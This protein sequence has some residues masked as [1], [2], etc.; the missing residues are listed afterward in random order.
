VLNPNTTIEFKNLYNQIGDHET[1][2]RQGQNLVQ[3]PNDELQNYGYRYNERRIYSG[4]L[5]GTHTFGDRRNTLSWLVGSNYLLRN[6]P[7]FRRFRTFRTAGTENLYEIITPSQSSLVDNSRFYSN[8]NEYSVSNSVDFERKLGKMDAKNAF[9]Y[10]LGYYLDYRNRDFSARYFS[11]NIRNPRQEL[12]LLPIDNFF[13]PEN[14]GRGNVEVAEGTNLSDSYTGTNLLT[15]GYVSI[16]IPFGK[17]YLSTGARVEY[18]RQQL[19]SRDNANRSLEVDN[20]IFVPMPFANLS[21]DLSDRSLLRLAYSRT[22][23]RP[24]FRELAPFLYYDFVNEANVIGSPD[25]ETARIHNIDLRYEF[26]P[27]PGE[28]ISLAG[29]YKNFDKPIENFVAQA[30]DGTQQFSYR[31]ADLA[32]NVGVE[33][34]VRKSLSDIASASFLKNLSL[35]FNGSY[36]YSRVDLGNDPTLIQDR[37]RALQGQSP[38]IVNLAAFYDDRDRGFGFNLFYNVSGKRISSVGSDIFPTV[39]EMPRNMIDATISKTIGEKITLK[40]GA[41]NILNARYRFFQDSDRNREIGSV[42][43]LITGY[44]RGAY[45]TTSIAIRL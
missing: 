8:L 6:E 42:D 45:Y 35:V 33:L 15:A 41:Q 34:E 21:Y 18:N 12:T 26:Y 22:V 10:K 13:A 30:S 16:S 1:V 19:Q 11:Y 3:R 25:L 7:D 20:P 38:Y 39:Y 37:V 27:R 29:F 32:N 5:L 23:N 43:Q 40:V 14:I 28:T 9:S 36:I 4:Q 24:E 31:N 2:L 17:F 44:R